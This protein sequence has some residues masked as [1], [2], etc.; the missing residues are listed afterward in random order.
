MVVTCHKIKYRN[1]AVRANGIG[2]IEASEGIK[3]V[4]AV[5]KTLRAKRRCKGKE[6]V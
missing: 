4:T 1:E 3:Y 6:L 5:E 2:Y